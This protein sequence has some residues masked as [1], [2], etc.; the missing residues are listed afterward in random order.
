MK[1][2]GTLN[3]NGS[4][5]VVVYGCQLPVLNVRQTVHAAELAPVIAVVHFA[6]LSNQRRP[7]IPGIQTD[8]VFEP[9]HRVISPSQLRSEVPRTKRSRAFE[10][11]VHQWQN[12]INL[13][14]GA[15]HKVIS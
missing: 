14:E 1:A 15:E 8:Q 6:C 3:M 2:R 11:T 9:K 4:M 10:G 13:A 5:H 7:S 12:K